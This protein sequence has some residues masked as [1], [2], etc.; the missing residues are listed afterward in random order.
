MKIYSEN[1]LKGLVSQ[2]RN[3]NS[4]TL[5]SIYN[6]K[7]AGLDNTHKWS[8]VCEEHSQTLGCKALHLAKVH[9]MYPDWC[10]ECKKTLTLKHHKLPQGI[11]VKYVIKMKGKIVEGFANK[12]SAK[13]AKVTYGEKAGIYKLVKVK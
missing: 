12:S 8:V 7:Q 6:S 3:T 13:K 4:K 10:P 5:I 11:E 1:N 2:N 9:S